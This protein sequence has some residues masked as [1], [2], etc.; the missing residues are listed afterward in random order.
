MNDKDKIL[1]IGA[2]VIGSLFAGKMAE[3]GYDI[4]ILARGERFNE[5]AK[6]GIILHNRITN[7]K[8][9]SKVKVVSSLLPNDVY[10]YILVTVQSTQINSL[11][12]DIS[13]NKSENVVFFINNIEGYYD[14]INKIDKNRIMCGFPSAGGDRDNGVI[15]YH[16]TEGFAKN[17][18]ATTI[19]ELSG[20]KT[21]R[22]SRL[23]RIFSISG[24][25]PRISSHIEDWQKYHV[26]VILPI[27]RALN[28][29]DSN[30]YTLSTSDETLKEM[31]L[32]TRELFNV[33]RRNKNK[34]TPMI[35]YYYYLPT[36]ILVASYKRIMNSRLAEYAFSK[37]N[38]IGKS[39]ISDLEEHFQLIINTTK[40]KTPYYKILKS[41]ES[42]IV[43]STC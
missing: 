21:E 28:V 22:L 17:F 9:T 37:H 36:F 27:S 32:A 35:L 19:G 34:I 16:I 33:L 43:A 42:P 40:S 15:N 25:S 6:K 39:E 13:K 2:G 5:I 14:W 18:Q 30:N 4:T 11:L 38:K 8:T 20:K 29:F 10:N 1:I 26:A 24:F 12:E 3:S 7:E 31:I 23:V 41:K